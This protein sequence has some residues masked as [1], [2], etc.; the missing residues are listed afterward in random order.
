[1]RLRTVKARD[2]AWERS[3]GVDEAAWRRTQEIVS[4][5]R[6][7]GDAALADW[8]QKLDSVEEPG[9]GDWSWRVPG[10]ALAAAWDA[11]EPALQAALQAA[12]ERIRRFHAL[13]VPVDVHADGGDGERLG[14]VWRPL[15]RVAVY[16]PGGRAA[17]PSTV[18]MNVIPAQV[19]GVRE[20]A[21]V[22][23]PLRD[24]GLPHPFVLAAAH[25]L[26]VTEVY[27]I[28]GAQAVAA[29]AY[30]TQSIPRCDKI[31]GPG[32]LYVA[33]AKRA[34]MGDV[35]IDSIAGPSEV[36]VVADET[37]DAAWVAADLIAQAEHDP[38][39]GA[40][41]VTT[42]P[43]LPDRL[44]AALAAQ[45][46]ALPRRDIAR[47]ALARWGAVV[48]AESLEEAVEVVNASAPEHVELMVADPGV[49][50]DRIDRAGAV[51]VGAWTPEAVGDYY[52]GPNHVL[53]THGSARYASGLS[54]YDFLRRMTY[55]AYDRQALERHAPDVVRLAE[56]EGLAG[57]A[58]A[59]EVRL[60]AAR[61]G[62][63]REEVAADDNTTSCV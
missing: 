31:V 43:T 60:R 48:L 9:R 2:F 29:M 50:L 39:A 26:G 33:L 44:E 51:F 38:E 45:L 41:C 11:L 54:V 46:A 1:M 36:F 6:R 61:A 13:Q 47:E 3:Q 14:L 23:P 53:P 10:D 58:R 57:H 20:V 30:G 28:G 52:A 12:A 24:T 16:A 19:A 37:A 55:A 25:L 21:L 40:V 27:R 56:A 7:R 4:D 63:A 49:W 62:R 34:V 15:R 5:V 22:S 32:N 8:T 18:L 17:Y 59:V 42:D 35:G